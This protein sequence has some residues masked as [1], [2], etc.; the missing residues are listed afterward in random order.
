MWNWLW[1][2]IAG[3][4]WRG[5]KKTVGKDLKDSEQDVTGIWRKTR[6]TVAECF[7]GKQKGYVID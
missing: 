7:I 2:Q 3:R 4:S 6:L 5:V 1:D